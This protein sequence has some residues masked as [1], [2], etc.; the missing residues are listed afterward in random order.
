[1][2]WPHN[3]LLNQRCVQSQTNIPIGN[4]HNDV[5][6]PLHYDIKDMLEGCHYAE[7][8]NL[9]YAFE[10]PAGVLGQHGFRQTIKSAVIVVI[11]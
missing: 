9:L 10:Q 11:Q 2:W 1:M 8:R 6:P 3:A 5:G 4:S 7:L